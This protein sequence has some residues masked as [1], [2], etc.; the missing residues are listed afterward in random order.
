MVDDERIYQGLRL[1][2][3]QFFTPTPAGW[4]PPIHFVEELNTHFYGFDEEAHWR[5]SGSWLPAIYHLRL[6]IAFRWRQHSQIPAEIAA[7]LNPDDYVECGTIASYQGQTYIV[8]DYD[9]RSLTNHRGEVIRSHLN[10]LILVSTEH[11]DVSERH[12]PYPDPA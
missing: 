5:A 12:E 9:C 8:V 7:Q 11:I 6:P 4:R 1:A 3:P 10:K 2:F